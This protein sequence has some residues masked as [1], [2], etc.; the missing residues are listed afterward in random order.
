[1]YNYIHNSV[2]KI[3]ITFFIL[4]YLFVKSNCLPNKLLKMTQNFVVK[5]YT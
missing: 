4:L 3:E 5:N 1:M 2:E